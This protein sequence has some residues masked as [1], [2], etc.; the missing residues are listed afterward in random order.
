MNVFSN[1]KT[2]TK[3]STCYAV[4]LT[5]VAVVSMVVYLS[6]T[7]IVE[8]SRWVN[9]T[10]EVIRKAEAVGAAMIDMETW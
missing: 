8:T 4:V 3:I 1:M 7:S 9:H 6:I 2:D 5:M 10:Y